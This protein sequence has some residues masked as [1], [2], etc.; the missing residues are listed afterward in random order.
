MAGAE[1]SDVKTASET[2]TAALS[3][4][5]EEPTIAILLVR[6]E[7]KSLVDLSNKKVAIDASQA[8]EVP[9]IK[10]AISKAGATG[11]EISEG[12]KFALGRAMDGEV[13]AGIIMLASPEGAAQW[14][15]VPGYTVLKPPLARAKGSPG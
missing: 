1:P 7:I 8:A 10:T 4:E 11:V 6:Q 13:P 12:K 14:T 15:G 2:N 5:K 3:T 9:D